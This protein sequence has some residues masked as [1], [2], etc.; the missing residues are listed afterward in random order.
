MV[1]YAVVMFAVLEAPASLKQCIE[2][3]LCKELKQPESLE[4]DICKV[5]WKFSS[6]TKWLQG[7]YS[8]WTLKTY[9]WCVNTFSRYGLF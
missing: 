9:H 4:F 3:S 5:I 2:A 6:V 7:Q 1:S 8:N